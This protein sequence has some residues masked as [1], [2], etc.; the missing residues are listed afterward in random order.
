VKPIFHRV[1]RI[2]KRQ[3]SSNADKEN[4]QGKGDEKKSGKDTRNEP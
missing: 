2:D 4:R 3:G 1:L